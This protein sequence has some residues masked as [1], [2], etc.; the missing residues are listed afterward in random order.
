LPLNFYRCC[1]VRYFSIL[2]EFFRLNG[3]F[4]TRKATLYKVLQGLYHSV[5]LLVIVTMWYNS[6]YDIHY[7]FFA[8][9]FKF[10]C[11]CLVLHI[12]LLGNN[13]KSGF[14]S[15]A[16]PFISLIE[17]YFESF[18]SFSEIFWHFRKIRIYRT[19][20]FAGSKPVL[21]DFGYPKI[22]RLLAK[23]KI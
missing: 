14:V 10:L 22:F 9:R 20:F 11:Y 4:G 8:I 17:I 12:Y 2:M 1:C 5:K 3:T 13:W 23:V 16:Y 21:S 7:Q 15:K 18:F 6:L 19:K